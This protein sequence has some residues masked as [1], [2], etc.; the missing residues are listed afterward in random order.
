MRHQVL[1]PE[2]DI[3][4]G[5]HRVDGQMRH[6]AVPA[7]AHDVDLEVVA[8][9]H[10]GP[11]P[12]LDVARRGERREMEPV[13]LVHVRVVQH[14]RRDHRLGTADHLLRGLEDED[15]C[16]RHLRAARGHDLGH[17]D[18]DRRMPVVAARVH[19]TLRP[20]G[21]R[22]LEPL[23]ERQR[24]DVGPPCDGAAWPVAVE[25]ANHARPR[26]ARPH[27]ELGAV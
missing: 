14:A 26:D 25:N 18:G 7:L 21:E 5:G 9:G 24:V 13:H 6:G 12:H 4:R 8:R 27:L 20:G 22:C 1:E 2:E 23:G 3:R 16:A 17:R 15:G 11:G 19:R 10:A